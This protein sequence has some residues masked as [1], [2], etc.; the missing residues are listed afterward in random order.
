MCV[1][2]QDHE[3]FDL[4]TAAA[5]LDIQ[6]SSLEHETT[7]QDNDAS[8]DLTYSLV[9]NESL[10]LSCPAYDESTQTSLHPGLTEDGEP[11]LIVEMLHI[12]QDEFS[13]EPGACEH[14]PSS[15]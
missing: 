4:K 6:T 14:C 5:S 1:T 10:C 7:N 15:D 2:T 3:N 12:H 11:S 9:S 13:T 8:L